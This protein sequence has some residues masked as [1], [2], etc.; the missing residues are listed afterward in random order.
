[1]SVLE[2]FTRRVADT[3]KAAAKRSGELV[4]VT[5]LNMSI[6]AEEDKIEK[7]YIEIGKEVYSKFVNG[8][9]VGEAFKESFEKIKSYEDTIKE[10]RQ[11]IL[12]LRKV[13]ACPSCNAELEM[14]DNYCSKC[15][16]K[17]EVKEP[18]VEELIEKVCPVCS[19]SNDLSFSYCSK[20][21]NKLDEEA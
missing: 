6:G 17:Q 9:D 18:I 11:K 20:C 15:G 8:E 1:M 3:A 13:K 12:E 10:M 21:G 19:M 14:D 4:E 2:N 5:K 16:V 7:V